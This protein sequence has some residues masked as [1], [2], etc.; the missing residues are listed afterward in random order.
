MLELETERLNFRQW[1]TDDFDAFRQYFSNGELARFVGGKKSPEEAWRLMATYI[2]HAVLRGYGYPAVET[3]T[4]Q[5]LVGTIGLWKS[6]PWPETELGYWLL[7]EMQGKGYAAE[8]AKTVLEYAFK[9]LQLATV[10]SY[11]DAAN[12]P[13]I[14]LAEKLGAFHDGDLELLEY[15]PHRVYRYP[16]DATQNTPQPTQ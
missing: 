9:K 4:D 12:T 15:G 7:P 16:V 8:A 2:G 14:R 6:D 11:I 13:S 5:R 1:R 3:K 10:V